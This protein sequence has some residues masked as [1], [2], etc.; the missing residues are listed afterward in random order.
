MHPI[1]GFKGRLFDQRTAQLGKQS[2]LEKTQ[3]VDSITGIIR[4]RP[5]RPYI[6][7]RSFPDFRTSAAAKLP[8]APKA[9]YLFIHVEVHASLAALGK[10][11]TPFDRKK[12]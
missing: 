11:R 8:V 6:R 10:S 12:I 9:R 2:Q 7:T 1:N 4:S 5:T 3:K